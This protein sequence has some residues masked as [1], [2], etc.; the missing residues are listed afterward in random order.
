MLWPVSFHANQILFAAEKDID[1]DIDKM[2]RNKS[3]EDSGSKI[4]D[5]TDL[6]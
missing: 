5:V 1:T 3:G 4:Y 2:L 6:S